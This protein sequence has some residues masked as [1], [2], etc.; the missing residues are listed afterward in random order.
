M[1]LSSLEELR[2]EEEALAY[3]Q[4][5]QE[6]EEGKGDYPE[7]IE[8]DPVCPNQSGSLQYNTRAGKYRAVCKELI[9][10]PTTNCQ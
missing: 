8:W 5:L 2:A 7:E 10:P 1:K 9:Y 3:Q 6:A 4:A